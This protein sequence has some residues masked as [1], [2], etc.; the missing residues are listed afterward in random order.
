MPKIVDTHTHI[1]DPSFDADRG[2]VLDRAADAGVAAVIAVGENIA[3][4]RRNIELAD[5]HPMIR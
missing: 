3:D 2:E 4:A 5:K 1:C